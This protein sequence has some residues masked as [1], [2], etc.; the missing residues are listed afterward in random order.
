MSGTVSTKSGDT[1]DLLALAAYGLSAGTTEAILDANPR[2]A[3]VGPVLPAGI[4]VVLPDV[5][6]PAPSTQTKLWD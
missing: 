2:L 6:A 4:V 1:V 3:A 5:A